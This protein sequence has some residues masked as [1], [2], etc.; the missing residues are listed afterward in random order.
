MSVKTVHARGV[1]VMMKRIARL[2]WSEESALPLC[3]HESHS[4]YLFFKKKESKI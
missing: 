4:H 1:L 3:L 2:M